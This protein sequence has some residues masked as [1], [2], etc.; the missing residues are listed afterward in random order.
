MVAGRNVDGAIDAK[1]ANARMWRMANGA[2]VPFAQETE[3]GLLSG[4]ENKN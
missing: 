2:D 4:K 1:F 3:G